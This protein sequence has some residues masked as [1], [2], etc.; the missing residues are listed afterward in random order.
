MYMT[1][2]DFY[3]IAEY[4]NE[5][6]NGSYTQK[7]IACYAY[8]YLVEFETS[9]A[10]EKVMPIIQELCKLLAEDGSEECEDWLYRM[11][12]ELE[13][14]DMDYQDYLETDKWLENFSS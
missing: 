3:D 8:D 9:K 2:E 4:G 1:Y 7:E 13:L 5:N 11:A 10:K 12:D 14:I 6:W